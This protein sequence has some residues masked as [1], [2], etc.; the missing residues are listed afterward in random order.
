MTTLQDLEAWVKANNP[1]HLALAL[2]YRSSNTIHQWIK[3]GRIP[4]HQEDRV[5]ELIKKESENGNA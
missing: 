5:K 4:R 1:T 2:G 3:R